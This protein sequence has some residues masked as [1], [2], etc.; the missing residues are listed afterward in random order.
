MQRAFGCPDCGTRIQLQPGTASRRTQCTGCGALVEVPF[1][2]RHQNTPQVPRRRR[3][4]R[5]LP[6]RSLLLP[7]LFLALSLIGWRLFRSESQARR[8]DEFNAARSEAER[9][10]SE[11]RTGAALRALEVCLTVAS[12]SDLL[13]QSERESLRLRR[14]ALAQLDLEEQLATL[15]ELK[16]GEAFGRAQTLDA[17]VLADPALSSF[18]EATLEA[19]GV[20]GRHW[21]KDR[22]EI[23]G[24][25]VETGDRSDALQELDRVFTTLETLP[26]P[27]AEQLVPAA[28]RLATWMVAT[29][30]VRI[31][32][33]NVKE[34]IPDFDRT[35]YQ[36]SL[37]P[38]LVTELKRRGYLTE[39]PEARFKGHWEQAR[40]V[41][42]TELT[43]RLA[44]YYQQSSNRM[45]AINLDA[46]LIE[47]GIRTEWRT[48][49]EARSKPS[50][51]DLTS[52]EASRFAVSNPK[53]N[54][55]FEERLHKNA[56]ENLIKRLLEKLRS[57]GQAPEVRAPS[58]GELEVSD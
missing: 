10:E 23:I 38:A 24:S 25:I 51:M 9:A 22:L 48:S 43:E 47:A 57:L 31:E 50:T 15:S 28:D 18:R 5:R 58:F 37:I 55:Q 3:R 42:R 12:D 26:L 1:L 2:P 33:V 44:G 34:R 29:V 6:W 13:D 39:P 17:R 36:N 11:G 4:R 27:I 16:S 45:T 30:G 19:L 56:E 46:Q 52:L 14:D 54:H 40:F 41:L 32:P 53:P 8:L 21:L 7:L 20:Y 35:N 49:I